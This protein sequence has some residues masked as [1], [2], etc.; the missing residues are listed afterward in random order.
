M[1]GLFRAGPPAPVALP[2]SDTALRGRQYLIGSDGADFPLALPA[3]TDPSF[4][5]VFEY[6][7]DETAGI[8]GVAA[9]V[10]AVI[11]AQLPRWGALVLRGVPLRGVGSAVG[12]SPP[13]GFT[14]SELLGATGL[15][16]T[17]YIGGVTTRDEAEPMVYPAS[18]ENPLVCMD[19]HQDNVYWPR[20]PQKLIF[21][22][23]QVARSGGLNPLLDMRQVG[24][25]IDRWSAGARVG[26]V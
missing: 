20:P 16:L 11:D 19:L 13:G 21:F 17:K 5:K 3:H 18:E 10:R 8:A 14:F 12:P 15:E 6:A 26:L 23:E 2:A 1:A 9:G 22:Y 7:G 24:G 25:P 4:P